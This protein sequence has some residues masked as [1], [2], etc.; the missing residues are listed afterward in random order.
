MTGRRMTLLEGMESSLTLAVLLKD[1]FSPDKKALGNLFLNVP[2][3]RKAIIRHSTGYFLLIDL[4]EINQIITGG[5]EYYNQGSLTIDYKQGVLF[6]DNNQIDP[7]NPVASIILSP[8]SN[9]PFPK[10]MTIL[11]G[12]LIDAENK[13][14]SQVSISV[15][16]TNLSAVSGDSGEYLIQFTGLDRDKA[17]TLE[18]KKTN[19]KTVKQ[20]VPLKIGAITQADT[21]MLTKRT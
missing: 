11:R 9:Y 6:V 4:P 19:Y 2:R 10:G 16:N 17:V 18:I 7:K 5:G 3:K 13:P 12:K 1:D 14:I 20:S 8:K 15:I 21:V